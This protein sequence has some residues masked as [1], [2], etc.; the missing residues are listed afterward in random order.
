MNARNF[1]VGASICDLNCE[2]WN[3][4]RKWT[5][6]TLTY[7]YAVLAALLFCYHSFAARFTHGT[8]CINPTQ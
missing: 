1:A 2:L 3:S 5:R 8:T 7:S 6:L 4:T